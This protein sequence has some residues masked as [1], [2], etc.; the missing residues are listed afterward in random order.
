MGFFAFALAIALGIVL[1]KIVIP[2]PGGAEFSL[3]TSGGPL[4]AGL[5]LGHFG[6]QE[7]SASM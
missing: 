2:L 4:I 6:M 1:A 5:I 7:K 3:G